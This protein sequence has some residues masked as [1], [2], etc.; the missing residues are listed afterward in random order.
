VFL[1]DTYDTLDGARQAARVARQMQAQGHHLI[2]VRL[3]SGDMVALS[4]AVRRILDESGLNDV[5]IFASSGFDEFK[6]ADVIAAG[7]AIDAFGVGTKVGVS[8]DAP[9]LDV[10]YK[11]TQFN[12]RQVRK[13]S[14]HKVTLAGAKQVFRA[15]DNHRITDTIGLREEKLKGSKP[16][17]EKVMVQGRRVSPDPTLDQVRAHCRENFSALPDK[18]KR[19]SKRASAPVML[20]PRLEGLQKAV[21]ADSRD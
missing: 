6:I 12:G 17:L 11:M 8:A 5:K 4:R 13:L 10:V 21:E 9:F 18:Y 3:D 14:P 7:A 19:I 2:G 1:I 15:V 20:S 16:L